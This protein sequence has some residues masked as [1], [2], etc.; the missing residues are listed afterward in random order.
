MA[1]TFEQ[2]IDET[3]REEFESAWME[4]RPAPIDDHLP[5]ADDERYL[6]TLEE[7]VHIEIE[8]SWKHFSGAMGDTAETISRPVAIE[9]YFDRFPRL[10]D[11]KIV[12]RLVRQEFYVRHRYGDAPH[13]QEYRQRF[14]NMIRTADELDAI[15]P[16]RVIDRSTDEPDNKAGTSID[17][18]QLVNEHGR[19]GFG[20]VWRANDPKL[21]REVA[22][23]QLRD[24]AARNDLVR[25]RFLNEARISARLEHPG[26]VAV[27]DMGSEDAERPFYTMKFVKGQT[28]GEAIKEFHQGNKSPSDRSV[29]R[30]RLL[31]VFLAIVKTMEYAHAQNVVHSDLKPQNIVLGEYGETVILDWGLAKSHEPKAPDALQGT[32]AYMSPEQVRCEEINTQADIYALGVILYQLLTGR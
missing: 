3:L 27:H 18:Y 23:K 24:K 9:E 22:V 8:F 2:S 4:G 32:P 7:L 20:V 14:P 5:P 6:G 21:G 26:V 17:R 12:P 31:N 29:G 16:D 30:L 19:G 1:L 10:N 25:C 13:S 15:V 28:L 11:P